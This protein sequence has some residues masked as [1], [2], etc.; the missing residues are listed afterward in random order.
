[1]RKEQQAAYINA[2]AA[3]ALIEAMAMAAENNV[4]EQRGESMAYD[5]V[6]FQ[7]L[8]EKYGI[9]SNAVVSFFNG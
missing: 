8:I 6:D 3:C 5:Q 1:M 9:H 4:R 7:N 2:Q